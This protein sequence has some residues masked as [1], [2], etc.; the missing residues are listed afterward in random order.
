MG[1]RYRLHRANLPGKP[2]IVMST[3]KIAILVHGCFFHMHSCRY[4]RVAP[5]TNSEFW[6]K[7]R[8]G[9]VARDKQNLRQLRKLG[10]KVLTV[11]ECQTKEPERLRKR[12]AS[13]LRSLFPH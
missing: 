12:L 4:G 11:W 5:A 9:N 6:H 13:G 2:D 10:W 1:L 7:K 3:Q 8:S